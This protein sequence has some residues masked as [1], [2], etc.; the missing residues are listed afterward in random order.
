MNS[1]NLNLFTS[2]S[3]KFK[4][5]ITVMFVKKNPTTGKEWDAVKVSQ[6]GYATADPSL[7]LTFSYSTGIFGDKDVTV[8]TSY[9]HLLRIRTIFE[10][11]KN[12]I[13]N[14]VAFISDRG[15]TVNDQYAEPRT[16]ANIGGESKFIS[17]RFI[18][19]GLVDNNNNCLPA[20]E[21][22]VS[23]APQAC[24]LTI[25]EFL[26]LYTILKDISLPEM[27]LLATVAKLNTLSA[28]AAQPMQRPA[29]N[30]YSGTQQSGYQRN[31][32]TTSATTPNVAPTY[33]QEGYTP[34]QTGGTPAPRQSGAQQM[35]ARQN[36][37]RIMSQTDIE[38]TPVDDFDLGDEGLADLYSGE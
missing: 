23:N 38:E 8:Y 29:Y 12:A 32:A 25:D 2:T 15:L 11:M 22:I 31:Y 5:G 20:V 27:A 28:P 13:M 10:D 18:A 1:L 3:A 35:P 19:D 16:I 36:Q 21:L 34:R 24:I 17:F 30:R 7:F 6:S 37:G 33:N 9:P 14:N 26:T 4:L